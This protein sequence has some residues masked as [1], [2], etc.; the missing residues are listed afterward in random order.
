MEPGLLAVDSVVEGDTW[1]GIPL[2]SLTING[3][4]PAEQLVS[5]RIHF[6]KRGV[7]G[8]ELSTADGRIVIHD[9]AA[10][11]WSVPKTD[12]NLTRGRWK[13]DI[14]LKDDNG[15]TW[16]PLKGTL[17]VHKQQTI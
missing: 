15:H 11:E 9:S 7:L 10:W 17:T 4:P 5:I 16:T 13:F 1:R 6:R 8:Q 2:T 3:D 14:E 12:I